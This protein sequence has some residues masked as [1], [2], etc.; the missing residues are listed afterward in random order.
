M[1]YFMAT[2]PLLHHHIREIACTSVKLPFSDLLLSHHLISCFF[3]LG[4]TVCDT[5]VDLSWFSRG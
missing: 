5:Q 3:L 2:T 1:L 4:A